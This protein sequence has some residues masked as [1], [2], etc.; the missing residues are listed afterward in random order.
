VLGRVWFDELLDD[1]FGWLTSHQDMRTP[2]LPTHLLIYLSD[3][4][5]QS[6]QQIPNHQPPSTPH[7]PTQWLRGGRDKWRADL[8]HDIRLLSERLQILNEVVE[9]AQQEV[10][11]LYYGYNDPSNF[12]LLDIEVVPSGAAGAAGAAGGRYLQGKEVSEASEEASPVRFVLVWVWGVVWGV[13]GGA[14]PLG[15]PAP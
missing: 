11:R 4:S 3:P 9:C 14:A 2:Y 15:H 10:R 7:T 6:H 13:V 12:G 5:N 1:A 8:R